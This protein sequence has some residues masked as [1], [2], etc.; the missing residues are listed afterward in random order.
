ME[1]EPDFAEWSLV[2]CDWME[3]ESDRSL[4]HRVEE[5]ADGTDF[6]FEPCF[7]IQADQ[8]VEDDGYAVWLVGVLELVQ[9]DRF[10]D[11]AG[12]QHVPRF[13]SPCFHLVRP[14]FSFLPLPI[15][16]IYSSEE[17]GINLICVL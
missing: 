2:G 4:V 15:V 7:G 10:H 13:A 16:G 11:A 8:P 9:G 17:V 14:Q 6:A 1:E 3:E 12:T 5:A